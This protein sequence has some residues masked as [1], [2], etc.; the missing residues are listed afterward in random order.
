MVYLAQAAVSTARFG[1]CR[2]Y[3]NKDPQGIEFVR[4]SVLPMKA[5]DT[6]RSGRS[7]R[8]NHVLSK[9]FISGEFL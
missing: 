9:E 5:G 4:T 6:C 2:L 8:P 3:G 1:A 7:N